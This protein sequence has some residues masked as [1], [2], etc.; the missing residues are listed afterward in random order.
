MAEPWK[1]RSSPASSASS[2]GSAATIGGAGAALA[3]RQRTSSPC[4]RLN[5]A[6]GQ[7]CRS[8]GASNHS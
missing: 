1:L 5:A 4:L 7:P 3:A 2:L 6:A 8:S